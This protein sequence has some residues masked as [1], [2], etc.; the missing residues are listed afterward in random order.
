MSSYLEVIHL[1]SDHQLQLVLVS[2]ERSFDVCDDFV[3]RKAEEELQKQLREE[4]FKKEIEA[5]V[6]QKQKEAEEK[7]EQ[8][9]KKLEDSG[10]QFVSNDEFE[11]L[12]SKEKNPDDSKAKS[13]L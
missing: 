13:E 7:F 4:Q 2:R 5:E 3:V 12:K 10:A 1:P 11:K 6:A 8:A 9:K